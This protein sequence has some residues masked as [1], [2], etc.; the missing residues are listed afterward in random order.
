MINVCIVFGVVCGVLALIIGIAYIFR[1]DEVPEM[2]PEQHADIAIDTL[3]DCLWNDSDYKG[4]KTRTDIV[5]WI[6]ARR[7]LVQEAVKRGQ[8]APKRM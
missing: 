7:S 2:A 1:T 6:T 4:F 8:I 5:K 3:L